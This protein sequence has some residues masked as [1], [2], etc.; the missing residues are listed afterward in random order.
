[1]AEFIY[2]RYI[3]TEA[4]VVKKEN[5]NIENYKLSG[6]KVEKIPYDLYLITKPPIL[7]VIF[8]EGERDFIYNMIDDACQYYMKKR[9]SKKD[10]CNFV[11]K[12]VSG[13]IRISISSDGTYTLE[14]V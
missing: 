1:M 11:L 6:Y 12:I 7:E 14:E 2:G 13:E 10:A 9:I 4:K 5:R 8:R 3:P